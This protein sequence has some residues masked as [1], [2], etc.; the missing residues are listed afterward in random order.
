MTHFDA[1]TKMRGPIL[2]ACAAALLFAACGKSGN[3]ET[4]AAQPA[5]Q[6]PAVQTAGPAAAT[7]GAFAGWLEYTSDPVGFSVKTPKSFDLYRDKSRTAAGEIEILTYLAE[8]PTSSY[9]IVYNDFPEDFL[10]KSDLKML[11][12][13]GIN[14]FVSKLSGTLTGDKEI[15]FEGI[16]G[17]E[18]TLTGS[19]QGVALY[20]KARF[21]LVKN[22]FYQVAYISE[23]GKEEIPSVDYF[24]DSFK[25][26]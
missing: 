13:N 7:A 23:S 20:G 12:T 21:F 17:R 16:A 15:M 4:A 18:I 8:L 2:L 14:G 10:A 11:L 24:L 1:K 25:L 22:R 19:S 5:A 9:G 3:E 6:K 26:K